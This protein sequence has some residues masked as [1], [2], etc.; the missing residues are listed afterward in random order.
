MIFL[1][2]I[3]LLSHSLYASEVNCFTDR[4]TQ[5]HLAVGEERIADFSFTSFSVARS[6]NRLLSESSLGA[7]AR[8]GSI[9]LDNGRC[10]ENE[11]EIMC[12]IHP[13]NMIAVYNLFGR[14]M[15]TKNGLVGF[16]QFDKR[17]LLLK[18]QLMNPSERK[19]QEELGFEVSECRV[20]Q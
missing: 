16:L 11:N 3:Y 9:S 4:N 7:I 19:L 12:E 1:A 5:F 18:L 15:F 10:T 13:N 14:V 8:S 17:A 20:N 2:M 6:I